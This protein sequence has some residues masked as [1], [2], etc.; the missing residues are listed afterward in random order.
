VEVKTTITQKVN[1]NTSKKS[2]KKLNVTPYLFIAPHLFFFSIFLVIPTFYGIYLSFHQWDFFTE[3]VFVGFQNFADLLFNKDSLYYADFWNAFGNTVLFVALSVPPLIIIPLLVAIAVDTKTWGNNLFRTIFYTP[4]LFSIATVALIWIWMLDTNAGL[5]NYYINKLGFENIPW[6]TDLPWAWVSLVVMTIWWTMGYNMLLF[7]A[8][9]QD[10]PQHLYEAAK[11]DGANAFQRFFHVTLPGLKGTMFFVVIMTTIASFNLFGQPYM[12]T[13][14]GPG[15]DTV[16]LLMYI[17]R[18]GFGGGSPD[19]GVA[20]AMAIIM[21][22]FLSLVSIVQFK[23]M[24]RKDKS[25][26]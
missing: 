22:I 15:Q 21:G 4:S 2:Y 13:K 16:T 17:Q 3:P 23:I 5:V 25:V 18:I 1:L 12:A 14:G 7:L 9:L 6:L 10:I 11:I 26:T 8:G 19:A 24:N 20:S